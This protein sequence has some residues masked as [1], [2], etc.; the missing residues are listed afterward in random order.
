MTQIPDHSRA[1]VL[2]AFGQPLRI[3]EVPV[4]RTVEPGALLV[5]TDCCTI[6]GTDVHLAG[7]A[8]NRRVDLPVIVGHEMTGRIVAMGAGTDRDSIGQALRPGDR[9]TW[10]RTSCGQCYMCSVARKP[11]LCE[12][13]RAYMYE[14]IERPPHL[15]GGFSD[16]VYV[17]PESGRVRVPDD[18]ESPLASM[19]SCAFRSVIHAMDELGEIGRT[20]TVVIQGTGP[21]GLLATGVA[22]M[23]GARRVIAIGAPDA[24]LRLAADF[25]ADQVLSVESTDAA[26]RLAAVLEATDGRG[27]DIVMEF[28]G[29]PAAFTEGLSLARR[30]GSCLLVGQL[31]PGEVSLKPSVLVHRNLRVLGSL[32]GGA[33]DYWAAMEFIRRHRDSLPFER[34]IS[35]RYRLDQVNEALAAMKAQAEIKPVIA[36]EETA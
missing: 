12:N 35:N 17:L 26:Q 19:A 2:R 30:G 7:G 28:T 6:C 15:L 3:E 23:S 31:G 22:R 21:L 25:G 9:I 16:Y 14:N 10:T 11:T 24:R 5:K 1:A 32:A 29:N 34:L 33:R 18:L 36:L 27:A 4:P 13:A 8:L 20:D